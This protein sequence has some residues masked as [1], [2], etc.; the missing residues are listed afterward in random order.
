MDKAFHCAVCGELCPLLDVVDF[1]KSCAEARGQ[2]LGLSGNP[3]YYA[4][5][6]KCG[7]CFAPDIMSWPAE[8][9]E[10]RIYNDDYVRVDPDVTDVRPRA[11]AA[12]LISMFRDRTGSFR[13]IDYGGGNGLLSRLLG[14]ADWRSVSFD[15]LVDKGVRIED[16]GKFELITAF[17][18]FEHVPDVQGLMSTLRQL[19]APGGI[20]L[21]S[22]LL[23]DG[24]LGL[25][26]RL[27]WWYASP[28]N[29]HISLFSSRSLGFLA[30][31]HD[32][33]FASFSP[34]FHVFFTTVPAWA[35]HI[36]RV[37]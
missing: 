18:V 11:N 17:E 12:T 35:E 26:R 3:V 30:R 20:I 15:P 27:T 19:L 33:K 36:I 9:F 24:N 1:N 22:T 25:N 34:G 14:E 8:E 32:F 29:G 37:A 21:F 13:H 23:S 4:L 10:R 5:C 2:F 6:P 16:L 31:R 7:F 28:R